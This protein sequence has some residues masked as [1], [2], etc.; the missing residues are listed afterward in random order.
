M[1]LASRRAATVAKVA[2]AY[3]QQLLRLTDPHPIASVLCVQ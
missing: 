3:M 1:R 2:R